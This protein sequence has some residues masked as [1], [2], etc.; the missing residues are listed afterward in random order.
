[1][2]LLAAPLLSGGALVVVVGSVGGVGSGGSSGGGGA[3]TRRLA[4]GAA[5]PL[6]EL[7]V[8]V[9][10]GAAEEAA[11]VVVGVLVEGDLEGAVGVT[12]DVAAL[13]AVVAAGEVA[14]SPPA[15]RVVADSRFIIG[16][17]D[18]MLVEWRK[19]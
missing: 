9:L 18:E 4:A 12:E 7:R 11:G 13:A 3:A 16:L 10:A 15:G 5:A 1:M 14:E 2:V 17:G 8:A 19:T 6:L